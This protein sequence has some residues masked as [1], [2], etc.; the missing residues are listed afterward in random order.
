MPL[1]GRYSVRSQF[2]W[3]DCITSVWRPLWQ[4]MQAAVTSWGFLKG[5]FNFSNWE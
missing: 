2:Q 5:C 1:P 4:E 3:L